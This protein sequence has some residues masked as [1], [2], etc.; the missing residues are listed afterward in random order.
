MNENMHLL[1]CRSSSEMRRNT[2]T[3]TQTDTDIHTHIQRKMQKK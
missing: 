1:T 3:D 2:N